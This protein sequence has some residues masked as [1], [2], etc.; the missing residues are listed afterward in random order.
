MKKSFTITFGCI[1]SIFLFQAFS[2]KDPEFKNLKILPKDISEHA[3]DSVMHHFSRSLGVKCNFCHVN[4]GPKD[5]DFASDDKP[6]KGIARKMMLLAI[7]I[8]KN[9]FTEMEMDHDMDSTQNNPADS[10]EHNINEQK[11]DATGMNDSKYMLV[12]VTCY[13]CHRGEPHPE[14][15]LPPRQERPK[16]EE[17][18]KN[19]EKK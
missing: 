10:M 15:K 2:I 13:T 5:W 3:L 12:S 14:T 1:I 18:S 8:N 6:E 4:N 7:D 19:D 9:Y 17:Q 16:A 11:K